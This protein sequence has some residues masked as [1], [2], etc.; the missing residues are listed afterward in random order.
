MDFAALDLRMQNLKLKI[1]IISAWRMELRF[2]LKWVENN[3]QSLFQYRYLIPPP[4][5][6]LAHYEKPIWYQSVTII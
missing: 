2:T 3:V 4:P 1:I 5:F 6:Y